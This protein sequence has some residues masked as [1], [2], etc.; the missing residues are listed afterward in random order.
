MATLKQRLHRKNATGYDVI[1]FETESSLVLRPSGRTVEQDLEDYLPKVQ[2]NDTVPDSLGFGRLS[3]GPTRPYIGLEAS[4][5][6]L[7]TEDDNV[8]SY[9]EEGDMEL[10][11]YE[12]NADYLGGKPASDYMLKSEYTP[13]DLSSYLQTS[14]ADGKYAPIT[15]NHPASQVTAGKL[16]G[17][18]TAADNIALD[19]Q[20]VRNI[21]AGTTDI[22]VGAS[23][24]TG[25]IYLVYE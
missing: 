5:A 7:L 17:I 24:P 12:S 19:Q 13:V 8:L 16:A 3:T 6:A 20:A 11:P 22:G 4:P 18:V 10:P 21:Y 23:L 14:V 2:D 25:V 15:H 9:E 1:H